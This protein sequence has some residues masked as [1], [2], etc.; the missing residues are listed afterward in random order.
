MF[1]IAKMSTFRARE[2]R[3][4]KL[5]SPSL[6]SLAIRSILGSDR[7]RPN[8]YTVV[9]FCRFTASVPNVPFL[10]RTSIFSSDSYLT[11]LTHI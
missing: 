9:S 8:D 6:G 10:G 2:D 7:P 4:Q 3:D 5:S 11:Y 1:T